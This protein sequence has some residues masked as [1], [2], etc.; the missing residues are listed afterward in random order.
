MNTMS[1]DQLGRRARRYWYNDGLVEVGTAII[2]IGNGLGL[3]LLSLLPIF[4]IIV[5]VLV[6]L[7]ATGWRGPGLIRRLK[8]SITDPRTGYAAPP[9]RPVSRRVLKMG[10]FAVIAIPWI[11]TA[12]GSIRENTS[13]SYSG[14]GLI[15]L[16]G[17]GNWG[18]AWTP[19]SMTGSLLEPIG[20]TLLPLMTGL[21]VG[22]FL[23]HQGHAHTIPRFYYL[24]IYSVLLSSWV[25]ALELAPRQYSW[26]A[27]TLAHTMGSYFTLMG[28]VLLGSGLLTLRRYLRQHP[29][30]MEEA[31]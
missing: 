17:V 24:A 2:L 8:E 31:R 28:L 4:P 21:A 15:L 19:Y 3:L 29:V 7:V 27:L 20:A 12:V 18:F 25:F 9:F 13:F 23:V 26:E 1:M 10:L 11:Y 30:P 5:L 6:A 22:A 14:M 16:G